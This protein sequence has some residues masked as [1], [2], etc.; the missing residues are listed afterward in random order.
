MWY[1]NGHTYD[2]SK[3]AK[4]H[5][6]GKHLIVETKNFDITYLVQ[7]NHHWTK[8][9][10]I[11][12]LEPFKVSNDKYKKDKVDILWDEKLDRIH[13]KLTQK[14]I[15]LSDLK[16]PWWGW[17][18]YCVF[19]AIYLFFGVKWI[20]D[21]EYSLLFGVFG[22][23]WAGFIQHEA[24]H[25]ALSH[26]KH[27][28]YLLDMPLIPWSEPEAWFRKHSVLHHQFTNT[29]L[30]PDFQGENVFVRHHNSV[31]YRCGMKFQILTIAL[32]V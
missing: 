19:G 21:N 3:F 28:N 27:I 24:S 31:T 18:Y 11:K 30:D 6:G 22:W 20:I 12:R 23:L 26:N 1:F 15:D 14:N 17:L 10:A 32:Y 9:Y 13:E 4:S 25:N 8:E 7:C 5:P 16:T 2:L 29:K